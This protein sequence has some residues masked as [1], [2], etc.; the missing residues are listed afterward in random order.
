MHL[1]SWTELLVVMVWGRTDKI[2]SSSSLAWYLQYLPTPSSRLWE[3]SDLAR[4]RL[5]TEQNKF[6]GGEDWPVAA[7]LPYSSA[8]L[9]YQTSKQN[10]VGTSAL[11]C[12]KHSPL[13]SPVSQVWFSDSVSSLRQA[14]VFILH[15]KRE[16]SGSLGCFKNC[17]VLRVDMAEIYSSL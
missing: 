16:G 5:G 9:S 6:Y 4:D 7:L 14:K 3:L 8:Q 2:S 11:S 13:S 17:S 1:K 12:C 10:T 15:F